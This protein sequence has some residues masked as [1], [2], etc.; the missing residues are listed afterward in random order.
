VSR[1]HLWLERADNL[2]ANEP[3]PIPTRT[4]R[5]NVSY[6]KSNLFR[7]VHA[8]G[9]YGG[10]T[11]RGDVHMAIFS[12]RSALPTASHFDV[13]GGIPQPEIVTEARTGVVRELEADVVMSLPVAIAAYAWLGD[14]IQYLRAQLGISDADWEMMTRRAP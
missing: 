3:W 1:A 5:V 11:P 14:K 2:E 9:V 7:V 6:Q 4:L 13:V 12:E 8:D 10:A